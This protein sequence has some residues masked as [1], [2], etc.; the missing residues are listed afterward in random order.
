MR[1]MHRVAHQVPWRPLPAPPPALDDRDDAFMTVVSGLFAALVF[2]RLSLT[3]PVMNLIINYSGDGGSLV[4]KI[5]PCTQGVILLFLFTLVRRPI[6]L[7]MTETGLVRQMLVLIGVILM[8]VVMIQVAGRSIA[9][10]YLL[11]TYIGACIYG[12]L[13]LALP[14]E[15]RR[16]IGNTV[17][18][19][20]VLCAA[21][22]IVE[23]AAS[24]RLLPYPYEE[25]S[26]RP[27]ALTSHPL[28]IGLN[29]AGAS[30]FILATRWRPLIKAAALL[31]VVM[32]T[33][34]SGA[35]TGMIFTVL[36]VLAALAITRIPA[37][38]ADERLRIRLLIGGGIL[39]GGAF[40]IA[41]ASAAGFLE[42][43]E[44]GYIDENAHARVDVYKV[45]DWV[46]WN[47]ILFGA[48][49]IAIKKLV[50]ERL[51]LL[52]ES[53]IVIFV[54]QFGLFGAVAF[55][56]TILWTLWRLASAA[57]WRA[58]V[59]AGSW[60]ATAMSNDTMSG[61]HAHIT[62]MV[63]LF[64]AFRTNAYDHLGARVR[65]GWDVAK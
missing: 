24:I 3:D 45:F 7:T 43:F 64:L 61:K 5:H 30:V 4:E 22:A 34:A 53:S 55:A 1:P 9:M 15:N 11:E 51:E 12:F 28:A 18:V 2:F 47:D 37:A 60:F 58:V 14:V 21:L 33:F 23:K 36:S 44:G 26:F 59:G 8:L 46:S 65:P 20:I 48:D 13:L 19:Y 39:I 32:G 25:I 63:L 17:L 42:R 49:L 16:L 10:G 35:R 56:A 31:V 50:W 52:I 41:L 57:D 54:F 62:I 29:N 27:T 6:S 40:L 38:G